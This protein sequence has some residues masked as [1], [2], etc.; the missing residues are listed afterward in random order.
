MRR[1]IEAKKLSPASKGMKKTGRF[2]TVTGGVSPIPSVEGPMKFKKY[3]QE[4][5]EL[6]RRR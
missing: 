6:M 1:A 2:A 3:R 5:A 4:K